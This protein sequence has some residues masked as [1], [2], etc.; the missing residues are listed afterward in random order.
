MIENPGFLG[1]SG[2]QGIKIIL[3]P[4]HFGSG[5]IKTGQIQPIWCVTQGSG[6]G[7]HGD[8][9]AVMSETHSDIANHQR[10]VG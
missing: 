9:D 8:T 1:D 7:G 6:T 5:G 10:M 3:L 4:Y 2:S